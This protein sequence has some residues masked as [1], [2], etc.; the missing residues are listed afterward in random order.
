MVIFWLDGKIARA[1]RTQID[2]NEKKIMQAN[3][4]T[5]DTDSPKDLRFKVFLNYKL[6]QTSILQ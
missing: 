5:L 3:L 6:D 2:L 1:F 4:G